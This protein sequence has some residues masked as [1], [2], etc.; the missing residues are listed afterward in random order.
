MLNILI[1]NEGMNYKEIAEKID[2][3]Y[4][5]L[6]RQKMTISIKNKVQK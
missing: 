1:F 2:A 3:P 4:V 5:T 6:M